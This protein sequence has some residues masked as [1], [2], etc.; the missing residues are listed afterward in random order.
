MLSM[1][2][3]SLSLWWKSIVSLKAPWYIYSI[4][5]LIEFYAPWCGHCKKLA[6][7]LEEAATTLKSDEEVVVAKMVCFFLMHLEHCSPIIPATKFN[8]SLMFPG[9]HRKWRA[10][11][12]RRPGLP[13]HVLCD[14]QREDHLLRRWQDGWWDHWLHQEEQG[15]VRRDARVREGSGGSPSLRAREGRA[16]KPKAL[17]ACGCEHGRGEGKPGAANMFDSSNA[18]FCRGRE[19]AK[20]ERGSVPWRMILYNHSTF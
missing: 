12:V 20:R 1:K 14:P 13:D 15:D 16:V 11:W 6:P 17:D 19:R 3:L 18:R 10:Q 5:V 4:A 7:I 9:C 2:F 8:K